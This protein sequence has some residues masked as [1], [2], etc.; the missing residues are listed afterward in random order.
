MVL[1]TYLKDRYNCLTSCWFLFLTYKQRVCCWTLGYLIHKGWLVT[2]IPVPLPSSLT[3]P[4]WDRRRPPRS[5][6]AITLWSLMRSHHCDIYVSGVHYPRSLSALHQKRTP[7]QRG[8]YCYAFDRFPVRKSTRDFYIYW[9]SPAEFLNCYWN[10]ASPFETRCSSKQYL[11]IKFRSL[12]RRVST[13][14]TEKIDVHCENHMKQVKPSVGK[15][16]GCWMFKN[17][18][19]IVSTVFERLN[20]AESTKHKL[21]ACRVSSPCDRSKWMRWSRQSLR[22]YDGNCS[23]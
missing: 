21:G 2:W 19:H 5:P 16:C 15:M 12:R 22:L 8:Q 13:L 1:Y 7:W 10:N 9:R 17:V 18:V 4:P 23:Y 11:N 6:V 14:F 20:E 3:Y